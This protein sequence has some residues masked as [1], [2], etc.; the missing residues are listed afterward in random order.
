MKPWLTVIEAAYVP[1]TTQPVLVVVGLLALALAVGAGL[2]RQP[3]PG[4]PWRA[5]SWA[6]VLAMV[7]AVE[8]LT[9]AQPAGFRMLAI[10][11][12]AL[13]SLKSV[14]SVESAAAGASPLP[15]GRWLAFAALWPGMEPRVFAGA[16]VR[17]MP[18]A[19]RLA[20]RGG[21]LSLA[22]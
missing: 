19:G 12:V 22:A 16:R 20:A 4:A 5:S 14:V 8:R 3:N 2:S 18:A 1:S 9:S 15:L 11:G 21:Q 10:I 13:W 7:I 6:F 17:D